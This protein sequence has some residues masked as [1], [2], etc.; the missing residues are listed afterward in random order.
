MVMINLR[1]GHWIKALLVMLGGSPSS[2]MHMYP[3]SSSQVVKS[4]ISSVVDIVTVS[5]VLL[6][7]MTV[8]V[9]PVAFFPDDVSH[10]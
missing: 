6:S 2:K 7:T 4:A 9:F 1:S 8:V 3:P 5:S 10:P